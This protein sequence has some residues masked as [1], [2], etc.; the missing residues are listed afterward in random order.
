[1]KTFL[2]C[3]ALCV[4]LS[5][6]ADDLADANAHFARKA[7]PEAMQLYTKLGNA[8]NPAAQLRLGEMYLSGDAGQVDEAKAADWCAKAAAKGNA[9][10]RALQER[11][12]QRAARRKDIDYWV[13]RYDGADI[14][15]ELPGCA[16]PRLPAM[17]KQNDEIERLGAK[18]A[19]W[20][21]CYNEH[22]VSLNAISGLD[23]RMPVEIAA[24]LTPAE[25]EQAEKRFASAKE[26]MQ[27]EARVSA[28]LALAD[29]AAWRSATNTYV[30]EHNAIVAKLPSEER[31]RDIE[32]R[33]SN[34]A[35]PRN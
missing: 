24:L 23:K 10:A 9:G 20:Q 8:G 1:M 21:D 31:A 12:K 19:K 14:R 3:A 25:L 28:K 27:E 29:I 6:F 7:F 22:A 5:A 34:Y 30:N 35:Q 4:S 16:V 17:S 2:L 32:A 11:L 33:K 15:A 18:I 26:N 13:A